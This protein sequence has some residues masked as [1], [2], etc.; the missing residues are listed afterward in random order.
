MKAPNARVLYFGT[1]EVAVPPLHALV[2]AGYAVQCVTN[3]DRPVGR[4]GILENSAVKRA[5]DELGVPV[6]QPETLD[7]AFLAE[8]RVWKPQVGVI[9]A[10]GKILP[11]ALVTLPPFGILNVHFSLLPRWRGASPV[12]AALLAGDETTGV[13][14][15]QLDAGLDTGPI[16]VQEAVPVPANATTASLTETLTSKG[17]VLL[18]RTL[19][20]YLARTVI[21]APQQ[22]GGIT[23]SSRVTKED[24]R[25]DWSLPANVL[26]RRIRAF[27]PWP[28]AWTI[29]RGKRWKILESRQS[30]LTAP[31]QSG[32]IVAASAR[33]FG[34]VCGD[35]RVLELLR[36]QPEGKSP[37]SGEALTNGYRSLL[38]V[39][40]E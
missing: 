11:A 6:F 30:T 10:Y 3:P 18:I 31:Q 27:V 25:L 22:S 24:A 17:T 20:A 7:A 36:A 9:V 29:I 23:Y 16:V 5:A 33:T 15:M 12:T 28:V 21:A 34:V 8:M 40:A 4:A 13:T 19:P 32:T 1:P 26:E 14:I 35:R 37:L 2:R 39:R 38:N